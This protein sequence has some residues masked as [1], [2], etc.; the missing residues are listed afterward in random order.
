MTPGVERCDLRLGRW[1]PA[2]IGV[3]IF[4][5][6]LSVTAFAFDLH[7]L[8]VVNRMLADLSSRNIAHYASDVS[9]G[10]SSDHQ[11]QTIGIVEGIAGVIAAVCFIGWFH[12]AYSNLRRLGSASLRYGS[13]WAIGAWFVPILSF[14]RPK[15]MAN[16][17]WR[18]S[19]PA[20]AG[21]QAEW[22]GPV[23]PLLHWWWAA[24]LLAGFLTIGSR[25]E[26]GGAS[27]LHAIKSATGTAIAA[28]VASMGAAVLAIAVVC[29]LSAR[30]R[31]RANVEQEPTPVVADVAP[32][33][34][35][36]RWCAGMSRRRPP[37]TAWR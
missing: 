32:L 13:G 21:E 6:V 11:T 31:Q 23:S 2:V 17:I 28:E 12:R 36:T 10:N 27:S 1:L 26:R 20:R 8:S 9:A 37:A 4:T 19:D 25:N 3:L 18:G 15:K 22:S 35:R 30:L 29:T 34:V 14:V 16:D 24:W 33:A 5:I 7:R